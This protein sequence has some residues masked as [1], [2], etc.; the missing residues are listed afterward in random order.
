MSSHRF[1]WSRPRPHMKFKQRLKS[2]PGSLMAKFKQDVHDK[3]LVVFTLAPAKYE[4]Q[5]RDMAD[6]YILWPPKQTPW[7]RAFHDLAVW[8]RHALKMIKEDYTKL[9][10]DTDHKIFNTTKAA[11]LKPIHAKR[12]PPLTQRDRASLAMRS[13]GGNLQHLK[14]WE[15]KPRPRVIRER[16]RTRTVYLWKRRRANT[17]SCT[18]CY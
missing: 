17:T 1:N 3:T 16:P 5:Y 15:R 2:N 11:I 6:E 10:K 7:K 8:Y 14:D 9:F 4:Q 12:T 13:K 18:D